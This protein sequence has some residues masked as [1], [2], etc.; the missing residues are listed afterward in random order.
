MSSEKAHLPDRR[1]TTGNPEHDLPYE[2]GPEPA[3]SHVLPVSL[4][5]KVFAALIALTGVTVGVS[6]ANLGA[7]S[8]G[9]ALLV[10]LIKG[11]F[12]AGFFMH[13]RYDLRFYSL[14]FFSTLLFIGLFFL[15]T[16]VDLSTRDAINLEEGTFVK[17]QEKRDRERAKR[18]KESA[19]RPRDAR[20]PAGA[21]GADPMGADPRQPADARGAGDARRPADPMGT[22][23]RRPADARGAEP[24]GADPM[25]AD[26]MGAEPLRRIEKP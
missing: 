26:P 14:V 22:D 12:V 13:L 24:M 10:A 21:R 17:Q 20:G 8:I 1:L 2:Q 25:G 5:L 11:G 19:P 18:W 4:Y 23:A 7:A 9:A 3:H 16:F 6:Y 15:L